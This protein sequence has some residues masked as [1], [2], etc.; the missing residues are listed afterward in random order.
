ML[1]VHHLGNILASYQ[2]TWSNNRYYVL[3]AACVFARKEEW[4]RNACLAAALLFP[5]VAAIHGIV[6]AA[7]HRNGKLIDLCRR[8]CTEHRISRCRRHGRIRCVPA[9]LYRHSSR[10]S[11]RQTL[12][13][14]L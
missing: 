5:A 9:M 13:D 11:D 8:V 14:I 3:V 12:S 1:S 6:L 2:L 10:A 4:L 7:L